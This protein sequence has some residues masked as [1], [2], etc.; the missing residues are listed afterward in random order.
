MKLDHQFLCRNCEREISAPSAAVGHKTRCC[1]CETLIV[2]PTADQD[3][4]FRDEVQRRKEAA[5]VRKYAQDAA[6][7][8]QRE[9]EKEALRRQ[10]EEEKGARRRKEVEDLKKHEAQECEDNARFI[11]EHADGKSGAQKTEAAEKSVSTGGLEKM[12]LWIVMA[13]LVIG[14]AVYLFLNHRQHHRDLLKERIRLSDVA[15][16]AAHY[17]RFYES[18]LQEWE[19]FAVRDAGEGDKAALENDEAEC[20]DSRKEVAKFQR[21]LSDAQSAID[22][23]DREN[24][25]I[26]NE[27]GYKIG[28]WR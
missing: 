3:R 7:S 11:A 13:L 16:N 14:V 27:L 21:E 26:A 2:V 1:L 17:L 20:E 22:A 5:R 28:E 18:N 23:F 8:V 10:R 9:R 25:G 12:S 19:G 4:Q 15:Q 6:K 24:L